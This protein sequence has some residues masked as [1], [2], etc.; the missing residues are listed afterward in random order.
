[1]LSTSGNPNANTVTQKHFKLESSWDCHNAMSAG[2]AGT[3]AAQQGLLLLPSTA[4][5]ASWVESL[6]SWLHGVA[7]QYNLQAAQQYNLQLNSS[8]SHSVWCG[9]VWI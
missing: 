3:V 8:S 4:Q 1:M 2:T 9:V 7:Q 5:A 6:H